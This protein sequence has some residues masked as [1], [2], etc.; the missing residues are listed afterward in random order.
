MHA[1]VLRYLEAVAREGSIR[2]AAE[3][4]N[5][6]ASAINRQ[7]LKLEQEFGT[8]LF[9]RRP[10]GLRLT[11]PGKL[12]LA[13]ARETMDE[14][15]R[16]R[17]DVDDLR[18]IVSGA[19]TIA[20]LDSLTVHFLPDPLAQFIA[21]HPAVQVRVVASDPSAA[22]GAITHGQA[23]IGLTFEPDTRVGVKV[24]QSLACDMCAIMV[25]DHPL[26]GRRS[27]TLAECA[28]YPLAF[29]DETGSIQ[30]FLGD[31]L[32][33]FKR[34]HKPV[35]ISNTIGLTKR[36]IMRGAGIAFFTRLGFTEELADGR[37][38]AVPLH[39]ERLSKLRLSL[40]VPADRI[41]TVAAKATSIA[42]S[43]ICWAA[44]RTSPV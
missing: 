41:P 4:L 18:G 21:A 39:G 30:P 35:L 19:V 9:D 26:A 38:T 42:V 16:L 37:L 24:L 40:M 23:D 25:P 3:R 27:L 33:V 17:G 8:L 28:D 31:E 5:I 7:I 34:A 36:L 1:A 13:H 44:P 32:D 15:D 6:S 20:T 22:L 43:L 14:Y 29:Q 10:T 11:E 2:K 12:V